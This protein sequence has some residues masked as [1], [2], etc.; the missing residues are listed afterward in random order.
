MA[1]PSRGWS[2]FRTRITC[3]AETAPDGLF[4]GKVRNYVVDVQVVEVVGAEPLPAPIT[5]NLWSRPHP[6]QLQVGSARAS[7]CNV[8]YCSS[9]LDSRLIAEVLESN[10][11]CPTKRRCFHVLAPNVCLMSR[12]R[13]KASRTRPAW[14]AL[15]LMERTS[16]T[17]RSWLAVSPTFMPIPR[18]D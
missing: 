2:T 17:W 6:A 15:P 7:R 16:A 1:A 10:V 13:D 5:A 14:S 12:C 9:G 8:Y 11:G 18:C 3:T 4:D